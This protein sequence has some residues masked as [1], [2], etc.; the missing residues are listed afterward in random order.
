MNPNYPLNCWYVA[1]TGTEVGDGL[2]SRRM[3]G[4]NI[5]LYRT[6]DGTAVA[7]DDRCLHR[8]FPLSAGR[9]EGDR[10]VCGYHGLVYGSNG[11]C[12]EVPSQD[13]VPQGA[14]VRT[15]PVIE[16]GPFVWIW[17][18]DPGSAR[19]SVPP[20]TPWLS[21]EGWAST[22]ELLEVDVNF[23]LLHE[24]YL[25]LTNV[26]AMHP[27]AVPPGIESLPPLGEVEVAEG[28]VAYSRTL[29]PS[30]LAEWE[31]SATGLDPRQSY[32]RREQGIFVSAGLHVQSYSI[33]P[34]EV[35]RLHAFT[36]VTAGATRVFRHIARDFAL[37]QS[38]VAGRLRMTFNEMGRRDFDV[39]EVVHQV[40]EEDHRPSRDLNIKADR[41]A[42]RA[43]RVVQAMLDEERG[44]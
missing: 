22:G 44:R 19:L 42:L 2:V 27:K 13:N 21:E 39:L 25:D 30:A 32:P 20:E 35:V 43:R 10:I 7:M 6:G 31:F 14:R 26:F 38:G 15:Y 33:G 9:R 37:D 40:A 11:V 29:T 18:G 8:G 5:L 1:A 34:C 36:P 24:H 16:Q 41:A 17:P 28:S 4:L 3:L 23:L 12:V